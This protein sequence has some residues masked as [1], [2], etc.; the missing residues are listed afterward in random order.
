M[1]KE[2]MRP[3]FKIVNLQT[4]DIISASGLIGGGTIDEG[5]GDLPFIPGN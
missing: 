4:E 1:K 3:E 5:D 2:Y